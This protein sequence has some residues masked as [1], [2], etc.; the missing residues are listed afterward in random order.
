ML[1]LK[2]FNE[3]CWMENK[4]ETEKWWMWLFFSFNNENLTLHDFNTH[5]AHMHKLTLAAMIIFI[6]LVVLVLA[7]FITIKTESG[8]LFFELFHPAFANG[9]FTYSA[10]FSSV[11]SKAC[12]QNHLSYSGPTRWRGFP[13]YH[14]MTIKCSLHRWPWT[15]NSHELNHS[16]IPT[17]TTIKNDELNLWR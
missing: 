15:R 16:Y 10:K 17:H 2:S 8:S 6:S 1:I 9:L 7:V 5:D 11:V 12:R 13:Q 14:L 3:F 4:H